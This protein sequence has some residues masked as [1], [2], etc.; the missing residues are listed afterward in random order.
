MDDLKRMAKSG[1]LRKAAEKSSNRWLENGQ[2]R[3]IPMEEYINFL[4]GIQEMKEGLDA[5]ETPHP[6]MVGEKYSV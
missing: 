6:K 2:W 1:E 5:V 3:E 4:H